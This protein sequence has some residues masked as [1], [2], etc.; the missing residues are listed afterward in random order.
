MFS[1]LGAVMI[2][3]YF[4]FFGGD[5]ADEGSLVSSDTGLSDNGGQS[6]IQQEFLPILLN[7]KNLK[8]DDSIFQDPAF[9]SLSDSSIVLVPDGNEGRPNPFAPI[10]F[11]AVGS[12][13]A[14]APGTSGAKPATFTAPAN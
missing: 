4:S 10:G 13:S 5:T 7:I 1:V 14:V 8:L 11:D 12:P 6:S 2:F 9:L 3:G